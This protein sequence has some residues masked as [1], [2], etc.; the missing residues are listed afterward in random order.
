LREYPQQAFAV[1]RLELSLG[2]VCARLRMESAEKFGARP[3]V[4]LAVAAPLM[5]AAAEACLRENGFTVRTGGV[6]ATAVI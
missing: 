2:W 4:L 3:Q 5:R 1:T 6:D